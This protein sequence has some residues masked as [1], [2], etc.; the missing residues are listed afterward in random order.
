[1]ISG[2]DELNSEIEP[3]SPWV[4]TDPPLI[5]VGLRLMAH[6]DWF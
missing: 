6:L 2:I 5:G 1:M 4:S 3:S